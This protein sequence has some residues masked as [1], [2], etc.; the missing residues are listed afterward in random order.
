MY[1]QLAVLAVVDGQNLDFAN[2]VYVVTGERKNMIT[3]VW[4]KISVL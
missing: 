1:R 2:A 4:K 3:G